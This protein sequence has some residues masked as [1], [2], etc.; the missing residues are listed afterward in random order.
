VYKLVC[1]YGV[2]ASRALATYVVV[3]LL[4]GLALRYR[5]FWF[6]ADAFKVTA[7]PVLHFSNYW[8]CVAIAAQNSVTFFGGSAGGWTAAGIALLFVVHL[9][10]PAAFA[11]ILLALRSRVQR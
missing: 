8:D 6:V 1:A 10:G 7:S 3:L 11:F 9:V 4:T 5:T 2:R